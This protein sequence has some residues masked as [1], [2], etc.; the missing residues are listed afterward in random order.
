MT[1][2][3]AFAP[4]WSRNK[5]I[6]RIGKSLSYRLVWAN[7]GVY[8][9]R[10]PRLDSIR[11]AGGRVPLSFPESERSTQEHELGRIFF[12]DCYRIAS[13]ERPVR[14][15]LDIGA[16]IGLFTLAARRQFPKAEIHCYEPNPS[17][18]GHLRA[19]CASVGARLHESAVGKTNG[20]VSLDI[21][22]DSMHTVTNAAASGGVP[23]E[24]FSSVI[25]SVGAVD[26]LK[27]D[28]EGAEWDIFECTDAWRAVRS[29]TMEYHL[30]AKAGSTTDSLRRQL[31]GLG[32]TQI[33]FEPS[34]NGPW[35]FAF[36]N[37]L[38]A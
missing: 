24:S 11:I 3:G 5:V 4:H 8:Y 23:L 1:W 6:S 20:V 36:A 34:P 13:V 19:H 28:C 9:I 37:R 26:L 22:G 15:V 32:F 30:W 7:L 12:D 25:A 29:L 27:L 2:H 38:L 18:L 33:E 16:N 14:T 17:V 35:G 21:S 31:S 10:R